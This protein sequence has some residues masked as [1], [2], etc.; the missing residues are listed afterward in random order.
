MKR[1][2]SF[3]WSLLQSRRRRVIPPRM[4]TYTVTFSCN[5]KCIMCDSW[6]MTSPDDLSLEELQSIVPQLPRMDAIRLT[7]GEP[8]V[9]K[10]LLEIAHL[11]QDHLKPMILH[12]TTN[13]FLTD[14]IVR[15]CEQRQQKNPLMVLISVDGIGEKHNHIRGN[16]NAFDHVTDTIRELAPRRKELRLHL[17]VNQTIVDAEGIEHYRRLR[18][19]LKPWDIRNQMVMAYDVSATYNLDRG[20]DVAPTEMGELTTFG[21]F[22]EEQV[23]ELVDEGEKGLPNYQCAERL[24]ERDYLR[25]IAHRLLANQGKP[26]P[27]CVALNAHLRLFPNGDVPTCQFNSQVVGNLRRE[28]FEELWQKATTNKQREWVAK[29]PGCWAECEVL[30]SA[31]Y[32]GDLARELVAGSVSKSLMRLPIIT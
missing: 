7:G 6:K 3:L 19:F 9:R 8:F 27:R 32:T 25:G 2:L 11:M 23:R 15:F 20:V 22:T 18:E 30:P 26:N 17:A 1:V 10:D 13:A 29:C 21:Q 31:I 4:L 24:V 5:A 16:S 14:R 28:S 12:I